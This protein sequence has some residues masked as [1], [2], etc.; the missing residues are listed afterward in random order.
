[1]RPMT[2][3]PTESALS[4]ILQIFLA[5]VSESEPAV[6]PAC[7]IFALTSISC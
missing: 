4:M 7:E 5:C 2:G 6:Q 3:A 1:L